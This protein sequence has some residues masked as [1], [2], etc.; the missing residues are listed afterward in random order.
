V[1]V[2]SLF[3]PPRDPSP[4]RAAYVHLPGLKLRAT[5]H[6]DD[7]GALVHVPI[8]KLEI[9]LSRLGTHSRAAEP[10]PAYPIPCFPCLR[11]REQ[12]SWSICLEAGIPTPLQV[13]I[14][15]GP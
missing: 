13:R 12:C 6:D 4:G 8:V 5:L 2:Y 9:W 14:V 3:P 7:G 11:T 10:A 1:I 15:A